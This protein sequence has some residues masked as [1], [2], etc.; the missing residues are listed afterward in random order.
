ME[1]RDFCD[2]PPIR[3][4]EGSSEA[5]PPICT[6]EGSSEANLPIRNLPICNHQSAPPKVA[7]KLIR[8]S[9]NLQSA[10]L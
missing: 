6:A 4:A 7:A 3:T 9:A 8:Q 10:N 2:L 1:H 5:N